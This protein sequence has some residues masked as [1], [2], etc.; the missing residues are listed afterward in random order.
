MRELCCTVVCVFGVRASVCVYMLKSRLCDVYIDDIGT[1]SYL[2]ELS[3]A[4][5]MRQHRKTGP[6]HVMLPMCL[7]TCEE[8]R[9]TKLE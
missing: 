2:Q 9:V 3:N 1:S 5:R 4:L 7:E 8:K 6:A